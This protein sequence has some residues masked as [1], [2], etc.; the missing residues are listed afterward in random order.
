MVAYG[1]SLHDENTY[2]VIRQFDDLARREDMEDAYDSSDGWRKG[3]RER[4]VALIE[5]CIDIVLEVDESTALGLRGNGKNLVEVRSYNLKPGTGSDF[6]YLFGEEASPLLRQW[7]VD[8]VAFRLSLQDENIYYLMCRFD[9]LSQ[10]EASEDS[11][12]GSDAWR[13]G[14]RERILALIE[15]YTEVVL[16]LDEVTVSGLRQDNPGDT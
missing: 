7:N 12:Y 16:A 4:M 14:P 1:P 2:Y 6:D 3:P 9:S 5:S 8:V 11:F 10:R 15:N 13:K